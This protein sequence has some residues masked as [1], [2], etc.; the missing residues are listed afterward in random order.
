MRASV[1]EKFFELLRYSI[2]S[3]D[4]A[5]I[6]SFAEMS[7]I[8][9]MAKKQSLMAVLLE[10]IKRMDGPD[11][12]MTEVETD[13]YEN[14]IMEW[15]GKGMLS[16]RNNDTLNK[17]VAGVFD[18][19]E[20]KGF[21][22]CLLKGQG[23]ALLYPH[24]EVRQVGDIDLWIRLKNADHKNID[25]DVRNIIAFVRKEM[26]NSRALYHHID[27][28]KYNGTEVELHYRP[29]F[30]LNLIS[31]SRLQK[32]FLEHADD[33]F[34]HFVE[35][36]GAQ[37]AVP[38]LHFNIVF[39]LS[40]IYQHL[41]HEGIGLRQVL[42]YF[43]LLVDWKKARPDNWTAKDSS[44]E[45]KYLGLYH[46]AGALMWILVNEF[47]MNPDFVIVEPDERRGKFV[48]NEILQG[49][50]FGKFDERA[51]SGVYRSPIMANLQRLKRDARMLSYFP[52]ESLGEPFFRIYH[53][54]WRLKHRS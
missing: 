27:Y 46:I 15:V 54:I 16:A 14:L 11:S 23:N 51:L 47:G 8:Y 1:Q 6:L 25:R 28:K 42:D 18:E 26:P 19:F 45:L 2:G 13:A 22:C 50:N 4:I 44:S 24:P 48:L 53:W 33:Q 7:E 35:I 43:W 3:S 34:H 17:N 52:G 40:H 5:P 30:M 49:G 21:E 36:G 12:K 10:G 20:K 37:I 29:H 38:T 9:A 41:F 32:Y 39:Q 31:N